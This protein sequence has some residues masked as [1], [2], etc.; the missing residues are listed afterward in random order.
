MNH[1][2]SGLFYHLYR[3]LPFFPH[4]CNP[5]QHSPPQWLNYNYTHIRV[6]LPCSPHTSNLFSFP[7]PPFPHLLFHSHCLYYTSFNLS[8]NN[9][10]FPNTLLFIDNTAK[11]FI[12]HLNNWFDIKFLNSLL[13]NYTPKSV[14]KNDT[15]TSL[16]TIQAITQKLSQGKDFRWLKIPTN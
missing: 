6:L 3:L 12:Y 11:G 9:F 14:T 13:L 1:S 10:Y 2:M 5:W 16:T 4:F 15:T 8:A 7:H